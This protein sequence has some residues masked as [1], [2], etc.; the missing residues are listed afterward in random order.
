MIEMID[1][2]V[3]NGESLVSVRGNRIDDH[4]NLKKIMV[5]I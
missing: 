1:F 3:R 5:V 4:T 2:K